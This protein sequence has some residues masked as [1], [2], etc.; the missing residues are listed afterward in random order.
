MMNNLIDSLFDALLLRPEMPHPYSKC[1]SPVTADVYDRV[2]T[3]IWY[4]ITI[5][6]RREIY[7]SAPGSTETLATTEQ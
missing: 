7:A 1:H 4:G 2:T 5:D 6:L 3:T